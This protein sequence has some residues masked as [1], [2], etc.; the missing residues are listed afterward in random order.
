M[1]STNEK[2]MEV[3]IDIGK[4]FGLTDEDF[5]KCKVTKENLFNT[6]ETIVFD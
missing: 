1:E 3:I 6:N 5:E 4:A 2:T